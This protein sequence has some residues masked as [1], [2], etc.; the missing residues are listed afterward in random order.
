MLNHNNFELTL[1]DICCW[2]EAALFFNSKPSSRICFINS[3]VFLLALEPFVAALLVTA[4]DILA[5]L[6]SEHSLSIKYLFY[7]TWIFGFNTLSQLWFKNH[8]RIK[9]ILIPILQNVLA[10]INM[11]PFM[12]F[13]ASHIPHLNTKGLI[14]NFFIPSAVT[15]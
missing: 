13:D 14:T 11:T 9:W 2:V 10:C 5:W 3:C 15:M 8:Y 1:N 6:N 4:S 7:C 12:A